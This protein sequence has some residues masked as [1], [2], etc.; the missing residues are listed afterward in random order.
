MS[1]T[2]C[3]ENGSTLIV[4]SVGCNEVPASTQ[5]SHNQEESWV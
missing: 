1:S 5:I 2:L 3:Y 4:K